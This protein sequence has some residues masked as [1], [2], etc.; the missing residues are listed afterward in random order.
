MSGYVM[1]QQPLPR[2]S[3]GERR[4]QFLLRGEEGAR[5]LPARKP[6]RRE[7]VRTEQKKGEKKVM[8]THVR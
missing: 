2:P 1:T 3:P 8:L 7:R 4:M 5:D 6:R